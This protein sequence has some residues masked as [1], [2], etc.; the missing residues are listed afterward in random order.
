[1]TKF[2]G[3]LMVVSQDSHFIYEVVTDIFHFHRSKL[4]TYSGDILYCGGMQ[5]E[6][7][8]RQIRIFDIQEAKRQHLQK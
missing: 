4:T 5:E 8:Q 3:M 2:C 6:D 7:K 1:M